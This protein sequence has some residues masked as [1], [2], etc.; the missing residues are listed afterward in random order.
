MS[1][2]SCSFAG[3]IWVANTFTLLGLRLES[4]SRAKY[5]YYM[6]DRFLPILAGLVREIIR[7][8]NALWRCIGSSVG[9]FSKG[10]KF[11]SPKTLNV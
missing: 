8:K 7:V 3:H 10:N 5:W 9:C 4:L 11:V 6:C 2:V 1:H